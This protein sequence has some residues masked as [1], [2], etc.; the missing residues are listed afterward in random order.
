MPAIEVEPEKAKSLH[1]DH[2]GHPYPSG[3]AGKE[4]ERSQQEENYRQPEQQRVVTVRIRHCIRL[5]LEH[6]LS[7]YCHLRT[8]TCRYGMDTVSGIHVQTR[9][10]TAQRL[11]AA[12]FIHHLKACYE[13]E[14]VGV[15][16]L[17]QIPFGAEIQIRKLFIHLRQR[18]NKKASGISEPLHEGTGPE[19]V[20]P[21]RE[22]V[23][24][25]LERILHIA[26]HHHIFRQAGKLLPLLR[27]LVF[28]F[29]DVAVQNPH[30]AFHPTAQFIGCRLSIHM[31]LPEK[32]GHD[33]QYH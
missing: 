13:I 10:Y 28:C 2:H 25:T 20:A 26:V 8:G 3:L 32:N 5:Y 11:V 29:V 30:P 18:R 15:N 24:P 16:F 1:C 21:Q 9:I 17:H 4:L 33:E 6:R 23:S 19:V 22:L 7:A 31:A 12:E 14:T 27:T